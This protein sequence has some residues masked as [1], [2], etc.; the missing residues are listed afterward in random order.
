M[1]IPSTEINIPEQESSLS[2]KDNKRVSGT[3]KALRPRTSSL[4]LRRHKSA[5]PDAVI[6]TAPEEFSTEEHEMHYKIASQFF[7]YVVYA[8]KIQL[9]N[10][11]NRKERKNR[12][13]LLLPYRLIILRDG[14][15][16]RFSIPLLDV[17]QI[18]FFDADFR[19][20]KII[21][22]FLG[23]AKTEEIIVIPCEPTIASEIVTKLWQ[24]AHL[25]MAKLPPGKQIKFEVPDFLQKQWTPQIVS[26]FD[27]FVC[28]Y[29]AFCDLYVTRPHH[30]I[31]K[32]IN[33]Y[34]ESSEKV[35][36]FRAAFGHKKHV[37]IPDLSAVC[38]LFSHM[39][40]PATIASSDYWFEEDVLSSL[41]LTAMSA[42]ELI[43][44]HAKITQKSLSSMCSSMLKQEGY[45]HVSRLDLS[46]NKIADEGSSLLA[47][48]I[49]SNSLV[50]EK[51]VLRNCSIGSKGTS[52][53]LS[54]ISSS[55]T[56]GTISLLNLSENKLGGSGGSAV[57]DFI[58]RNSSLTHL[59]LADCDFPPK[60]LIQALTQNLTLYQQ[61][62][63]SIN[64]SGSKFNASDTKSLAFLLVTTQSINSW[65]LRYCKF[66]KDS[67]KDI[68][69]GAVSNP[70]D[71]HLIFD[72]H[73][74]PLE[75]SF[76]IISQSIKLSPSLKCSIKEID[77]SK[78]KLEVDG[79]MSCCKVLHQI[80]SIEKLILDR[81]L[82]RRLKSKEQSELGDYLAMIPVGLSKLSYL[83]MRGSDSTSF[84][85]SLIS[86]IQVL[87]RNTS[88][89]FLDIGSN[90]L[91]SKFYRVLHSVLPFNESL[92]W[93]NVDEN[94]AKLKN[95]HIF[96]DAVFKN[97]NLCGHIPSQDFARIRKQDVDHKQVD[98]LLR[99][100]YRHFQRNQ[101]DLS[102]ELKLTFDNTISALGLSQDENQDFYSK[103]FIAPC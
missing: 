18:E 48:V 46:G 11:I 32:F 75:N 83:S 84:G 58:L 50:L 95:L 33:Q 79:L 10:P 103:L 78:C 70:F 28:L 71:V 34:L 74:T 89:Q 69:E 8:K 27:A 13:L 82:S 47:K 62:L 55:R 53:L 12:V 51:L 102:P 17:Q 31:P 98:L 9:A 80:V 87:E 59:W 21:I 67:V 37:S 56:N 57:A 77:L 36:D 24:K 86:V 88:I 73:H 26:D 22:H 14:K 19:E 2:S 60:V 92:L 45:R 90:H 23:A 68:I 76:G 61:V 3:I 96:C 91:S 54:A 15:I 1:A 35:L 49:S 29:E 64:L 6:H 97:K 99:K 72:F 4:G 94:H 38:S 100:L 66:E 41:G 20:Y 101:N 16:I 52:A 42:Q 25:Y 40:L 30:S 44:R 43:L 5:S 65:I 81:N 39:P 63:R 85:D 93:I 7:Q